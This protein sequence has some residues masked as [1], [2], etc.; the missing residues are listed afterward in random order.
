MSHLAICKCEKVFFMI[1]GYADN[2]LSPR[3][4]VG[5]WIRR[6]RYVLL[7]LVAAFLLVLLVRRNLMILILN[8]RCNGYTCADETVVFEAPLPNPIPP[9][10]P[11]AIASAFNGQVAPPPR[12]TRAHTAFC[13]RELKTLWNL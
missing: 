9:F 2:S 7:F 11:F 1:M 13:W 4:R 10:S 5:R 3:G 12:V 6:H 8:W